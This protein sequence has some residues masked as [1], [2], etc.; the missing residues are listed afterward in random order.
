MNNIHNINGSIMQIALNERGETRN[1]YG[2]RNIYT[3]VA[4]DFQTYNFEN[5]KLTLS[6]NVDKVL[7]EYLILNLYDNTTT[8]E[9][10]YN[11]GRNIY[12]NFK[13][14]A[15]TLLNIP[16]SILWNLKEPEICDNKLYLKIPFAMFFGD[17]YIAGLQFRE[18]T[19]TLVNH[20]N[21]VN[22]VSDYSLLCKTYIGDSQYR[23]NSL[24][25]SSCC[26]QQISSLELHVSLEN[27]E[28]TS[29]EFKIQT[30][31]FQGFSKG[32]FIETNNI[33]EL[34]NM[35]FYINDLIRID[36]N[37]FMIRNKSQR[38]ND[39]MIFLPFNADIVFNERSFNSFVGSINLSEVIQSTLKLIFDTPR[40]KVKVYSMNMNDYVQRRSEITISQNTINTHLVED[41]TRHSLM[42]VERRET[43]NIVN[44]IVNEIR[45]NNVFEN[46]VN[47]IIYNNL[48]SGMSGP[49]EYYPSITYSSVEDLIIDI[50]E[51]KLIPQEKRI[52]GINLEE[53]NVDQKYMSCAECSNNF[54]E[55]SIRIWL[56]QRRTC[57]SCRCNWSDF[58]VYSNA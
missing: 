57:P 31:S 36:Y 8:L 58:N 56:T 47:N 29:D 30:N 26:I 50:G 14:G 1:T 12:I 18:V 6:R 25:T 53:I 37:R 7:P 33:N 54:N 5:Y 15:Q 55:I 39:N 48:Y 40:N 45:V 3:N 2:S 17:I 24:D 49:P 22:Y 51:A 4:V 11:Y 19:F 27:H 10:I 43:S 9:T 28:D 32:F 23:R 52:C 44:N 21:L 46:N 20:T 13:I 34:N 42:H 16:L 35:R 38:I 41:F